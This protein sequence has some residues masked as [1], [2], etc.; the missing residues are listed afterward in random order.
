MLMQA[1]EAGGLIVDRAPAGDPRRDDYELGD[2]AYASLRPDAMD[3]DVELR[4]PR[5]HRGRLIKVLV[6]T[7]HRIHPQPRIVCVFIERNWA[8]LTASFEA[9]NGLP[10]RRD[11]AERQIEKEL[12][13]WRAREGVELTVVDY[14][15]VLENPEW[16]F[17]VLKTN[18]FPIDVELAAAVI[19]T[20]RQTVQQ[21]AVPA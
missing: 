12:S 5:A 21:E 7:V 16:F 13:R 2:E 8:A 10:L 19:D 14:D 6:G 18:G 17:G 9:R 20:T 1:L 15:A 4:W 3:D 11:W